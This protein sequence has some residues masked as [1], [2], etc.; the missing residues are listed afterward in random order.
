M[1]KEHNNNNN[2]TTYDK[3]VEHRA[4]STY[5][6]GSESCSYVLTHKRTAVATSVCFNAYTTKMAGIKYAYTRTK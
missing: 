1:R 4:T 3:E 6:T 5:K 2:Q